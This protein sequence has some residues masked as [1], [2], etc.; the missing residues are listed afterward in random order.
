VTPR[1]LNTVVWDEWRR[2]L[3]GRAHAGPWLDRTAIAIEQ[4]ERALLNKAM[5]AAPH[6][7]R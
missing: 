5:N 2:M 3:R 6:R 1:W 7:R 4:R